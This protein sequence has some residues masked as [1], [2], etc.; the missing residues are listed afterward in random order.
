MADKNI[1]KQLLECQENEAELIMYES[2]MM[3]LLFEKH[4]LSAIVVL[5]Y[6]SARGKGA[7]L[8]PPSRQIMVQQ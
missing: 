2:L 7:S 8:P 4:H 6:Y 3:N 5:N 1:S